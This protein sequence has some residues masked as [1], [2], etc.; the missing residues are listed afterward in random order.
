[1]S[2]ID[3]NNSLEKIKSQNEIIILELGCGN[4]KQFTNSISIDLVDINGVDIVCDLNKGFPFIPDNSIDEIHSVHFL[5]HI[6]NLGNIMKEIHR[7][8]KPKGIKIITVP[9]FSNPYFY[10]DYTH[11]NHFGLYS[12][13][14]FSKSMY[15]KRQVPVFYNDINFKIKS[16]SISFKSQ[17]RLQGLFLKYVGK[18]INKRKFS[19]EFTR[20]IFVIYSLQTK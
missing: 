7:I 17:Y 14:Y 10:S 8:L 2:Y 9:H 1:M 15:F 13:C 4:S 11:R 16:V 12:L 18:I 6:D 20:Q 3:K 19:L 5:E